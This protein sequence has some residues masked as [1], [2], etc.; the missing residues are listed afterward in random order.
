MDLEHYVIFG[1]DFDYFDDDFDP[2]EYVDD[3][4]FSDDDSDFSESD[5]H[6]KI[7]VSLADS[8]V[9]R[10]LHYHKSLYPY[11]LPRVRFKEPE[12][13]EAVY[14]V[15]GEC[16]ILL[17]VW[18]KRAQDPRITM[19]K[20]WEVP[21]T[22]T[23]HLILG[24][25]F[26]EEDMEHESDSETDEHIAI[27]NEALSLKKWRQSSEAYKEIF[28]AREDAFDAF[29]D[30][31]KSART[32]TFHLIQSGFLSLMQPLA[33]RPLPNEIWHKIWCYTQED[34][35]FH[36][37]PRAQEEAWRELEHDRIKDFF[38]GAGNLHMLLFEI[39]F[40]NPYIGVKPP[41]MLNNE[42]VSRVRASESYLKYVFRHYKRLFERHF[43]RI[44]DFHLD[45]DQEEERGLVDKASLGMMVMVD[46]ESKTMV[47]RDSS[48]SLVDMVDQGLFYIAEQSVKPV[49][50]RAGPLT[51]NSDLLLSAPTFCSVAVSID[52]PDLA[53]PDLH[54]MLLITFD[55]D[56]QKILAYIHTGLDPLL[57]DA[58]AI[59]SV[60][61]EEIAVL[62]RHCSK[63]VDSFKILRWK[64]PSDVE[65]APLTL[66]TKDCDTSIAAT[67][68]VNP[69][70]HN[71]PNVLTSSVAF[72]KDVIRGE[73]VYCVCH[74]NAYVTATT[75]S[76]FTESSPQTAT[77]Q[78]T[79]PDQILSLEAFKGD[80]V[81]LRDVDQK[82][83]FCDVPNETVLAE[84]KYA[85]ICCEAEHIHE[86]YFATDCH[87]EV[88]MD[89]RPGK[90][91]FAIF[92]QNL[93]H[94]MLYEFSSETSSSPVRKARGSNL[95]YDMNYHIMKK[96][97]LLDGILF[98]VADHDIT[99]R[100]HS[101]DYFIDDTNIYGFNVIAFDL[102]KNTLHHVESM[103]ASPESQ[104]MPQDVGLLHTSVLMNEYSRRFVMNSKHNRLKESAVHFINDRT[105][106]MPNVNTLLTLNFSD[107]VQLINKVERDGL[108]EMALLQKREEE[109]RRKAEEK[110]RKILK[111]KE[112]EKK[113]LRQEMREKY[114]DK[115][116]SLR[117]KIKFWKYSYGFIDITHTKDAKNLGNVFVHLS[118]FVNRG[119][120]T[121]QQGQ[122][123]KFKMATQDNSGKVQA[124]DV[125]L[126]WPNSS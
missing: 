123:V 119:Q 10:R 26:Q 115:N 21:M 54:D 75:L 69:D 117:G 89:Q 20:E 67:L 118:N 102:M 108:M 39:L 112:E 38:G 50:N 81:I 74:Q 98:T 23:D 72:K 71:D 1:D 82:L 40:K 45:L 66:T 103:F 47:D 99:L 36:V 6:N 37:G 41:L 46:Q 114:V 62:E 27:V 73:K 122:K 121:I 110:K 70:T 61:V 113:R 58:A 107:S 76:Y 101:G 59:V 87:Y 86:T 17:D 126:M 35:P 83:L 5:D 79:F 53:A 34:A 65:E 9:L 25:D 19:P 68:A 95:V 125:R 90:N 96:V 8:S 44:R 32:F 109:E 111:R 91:E 84:Y 97:A 33:P 77:A 116:V 14:K 13:Y 55:M 56:T 3:D 57:C 85:D 43:T 22:P 49:L 2:F 12:S 51:V 18:R 120:K 24:L 30:M 80:R 94:F 64:I 29:R 31:L 4:F 106:A 16:H 105:L 93:G 52:T 104:N 48:K 15:L 63:S 60:S 28:D 42:A 92:N 11:R 7:F 124:V 78:M 100:T 88:K